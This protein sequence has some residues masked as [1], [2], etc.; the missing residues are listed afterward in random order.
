MSTNGMCPFTKALAIAVSLLLVAWLPACSPSQ[1]SGKAV[2]TP[3]ATSAT[4][5]V[6]ADHT[7]DKDGVHHNPG[8]KQPIA[9]GCPQCHGANLAGGPKAPSCTK[10]HGVE[11]KSERQ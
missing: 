9:G 1:P 6:P 5:A 10:C 3:A 2:V 4:R 11:W 7:K 8:Y